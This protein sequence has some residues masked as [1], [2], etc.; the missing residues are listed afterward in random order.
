MTER[1]SRV[2]LSARVEELASRHDG[3]AFVTEIAAL[4]KSLDTDE[5][6]M[7]EEILLARAKR[8]EDVSTAV[9]RRAE[10]K[11]WLRRT[12]GRAEERA[13]D[14]RRRRGA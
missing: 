9:R 7:L 2:E 12:L 14:L 8:E 13:A 10:E 3:D 1:W 6:A 11:G 5:R 4:A